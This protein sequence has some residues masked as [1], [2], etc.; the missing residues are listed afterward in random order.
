MSPTGFPTTVVLPLVVGPGSLVVVVPGSIEEVS[1]FAPV[2]DVVVWGGSVELGLIGWV[3]GLLVEVGDWAA[4]L[5]EVGGS[6]VVLGSAAG[7]ITE[8]EDVGGSEDEEVVVVVAIIGSG[9]L[10]D[11]CGSGELEVVAGASEV[12]VGF[13]DDDVVSGEFVM[14]TVTAHDDPS[15]RANL[16]PPTTV[17]VAV[18]SATALLVVVSAKGGFEVVVSGT[19]AVALCLNNFA[20]SC[21]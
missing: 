2:G 12:V 8:L 18:Q 13:V 15:P 10:V 9:E 1:V 21:Q 16:W 20:P 5:I 17:T 3:S 4:G 6:E 7:A 11:V 19:E 14:V